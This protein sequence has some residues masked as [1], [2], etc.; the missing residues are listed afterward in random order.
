[1]FYDKVKLVASLVSEVNSFV[2][3]LVAGKVSKS[4]CFKKTPAGSFH[5]R[6]PVHSLAPGE[7]QLS[8]LPY[9]RRSATQKSLR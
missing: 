6:T 2:T 5:K 7:R 1:M 3:S 8:H 9:M 4:P